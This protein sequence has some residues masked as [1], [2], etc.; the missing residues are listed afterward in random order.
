M[1]TVDPSPSLRP[2]ARRARVRRWIRRHRRRIVVGAVVLSMLA[3]AATL[4]IAGLL[5]GRM[6]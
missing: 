5:A 2:F 1:P 3:L 6:G 4:G